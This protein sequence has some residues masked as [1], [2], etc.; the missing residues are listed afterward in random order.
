MN[1]AHDGFLC[2]VPIY[3]IT[4]AG[5][6][7]RPQL[8]SSCQ[9]NLY[10]T[11]KPRRYG[12]SITYKITPAGSL[13]SAV[14]GQ[15]CSLRLHGLTTAIKSTA[16]RGVDFSTKVKGVG[17][18]VD[19]NDSLKKRGIVCVFLFQWGDGKEM[20]NNSPFPIIYVQLCCELVNKYFALLSQYQ[21]GAELRP[22]PHPLPC[23][24]GWVT[25]IYLACWRGGGGVVGD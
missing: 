4:A 16:D 15:P 1:V 21:V 5:N 13:S 6:S 24:W 25:A 22:Q 18:G 17:D 3:Y 11:E 7:I 10:G 2:S 19:F 8:S 23:H 20:R 9:D 12:Q 14:S